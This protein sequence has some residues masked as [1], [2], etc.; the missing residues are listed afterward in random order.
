M[1]TDEI[2][3]KLI[4]N[5]FESLISIFEENHLLNENALSRMTDADYQSIGVSILGDRK[6]LVYL[7]SNNNEDTNKE[8]ELPTEIEFVN[9][10]RN[11]KEFCYK[12]DEPGILL[13]RKCHKRV[14]EDDTLCS[15]CNN[16][17]IVS[18]SNT[19]LS[20]NNNSNY[21]SSRNIKKTNSQK[22]PLIIAL[23][24]LAFFGILYFTNAKKNKYNEK[25]V[26]IYI[27]MME[28]ADEIESCL[29]IV[30]LVWG[31]AVFEKSDTVTDKYTK[32]SGSNKFVDFDT[33]LKTL[34]G[35]N[36]FNQKITKIGRDSK[37]ISELMKDMPNPPKKYDDAFSQLDSCYKDYIKLANLAQGPNGSYI[38][39]TS[40]YTDLD[41]SFRSGLKALESYLDIS[42]TAR[43]K[44]GRIY[45]RKAAE[46]LMR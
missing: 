34:Y 23:T 10:E 14:Y 9:I 21:Y 38:S 41:S 31:N 3:Q 8:Q 42:D 29:N 12:S 1:T 15:N 19:V 17:L 20:S 28:S 11:G 5:G 44:L 33:A 25:L 18:T 43:D 37:A 4:D 27:H 2:K 22:A 45:A 26:D 13:C 6:K 16:S 46:A 40:A 32:K 24:I 30:H 35:D 39:F 36:D 7:F